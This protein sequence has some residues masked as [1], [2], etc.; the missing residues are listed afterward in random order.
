MEVFVRH[1]TSCQCDKIHASRV[2]RV[3]CSRFTFSLESRTK[4]KLIY[5]NT[6]AQNDLLFMTKES[7]KIYSQ[8][9]IKLVVQQYKVIQK[10]M[11]EVGNV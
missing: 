2:T 4:L 6:V 1:A 7:D 5:H 10:I 11:T 9:N 8:L 3:L